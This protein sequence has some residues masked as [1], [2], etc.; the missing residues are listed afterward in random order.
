MLSTGID[1]IEI[2]R[3]ARAVDRHGR[4]FLERIYTPLEVAVCRGR[5]GEL[6]A[7]F[8]AKEAVSKA[9]GVGIFSREGVG[10]RDVEVLPDGRGKP[11]V[12]LYGRAKARAE[13]LRLEEFALS[14][15]HDGGLAVAFVVAQGPG[16]GEELDPVA[17]R[18]RLE[19]WV[20]AR[21]GSR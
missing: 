4:R 6:A 7:H 3:V 21:E 19:A 11:L 12:Y 1:V 14:L 5:T 15:T 20:A 16:D 8:A 18:A 2:A 10:W 13:E 9:L 17:W